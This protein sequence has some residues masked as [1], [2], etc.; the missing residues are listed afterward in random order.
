M[1]LTNTPPGRS[2][3]RDSAGAG[4]RPAPVP[5][6][7]SRN[8]RTAGKFLLSTVWADQTPTIQYRLDDLDDNGCN[9]RS[10]AAEADPTQFPPEPQSLSKPPG[11]LSRPANSQP[12]LNPLT[13]L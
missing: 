7:P 12:F 4:I 1:G 9:V 6:E 3:R 11:A 13:T 8:R 2:E 5:D 10:G